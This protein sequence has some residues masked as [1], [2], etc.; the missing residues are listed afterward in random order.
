MPRA[1]VDVVCERARLRC[2]SVAGLAR[3]ERPVVRRGETERESSAVSEDWSGR[4]RRGEAKSSNRELIGGGATWYIYE[5]K[6]PIHSACCRN[7]LSVCVSDDTPDTSLIA[8]TKTSLS[9]YMLYV[10]CEHSLQCLGRLLSGEQTEPL[11][12]DESMLRELVIRR[13]SR[14][15]CRLGRLALRRRLLREKNR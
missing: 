6:R 15:V 14:R 2:A 13:E 3:R 5:T 11:L 4:G 10:S 1:G 8:R 7:I 9:Y 12:A